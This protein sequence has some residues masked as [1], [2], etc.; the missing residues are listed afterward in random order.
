MELLKANYI[1]TSTAIVVQSNT[2]TAEF[3][4]T[5]DL[6]YQY[7]SSGYANDTTTTT[8]RINF[9]ETLSVDRI[10][11]LGINL[12]GFD[13]YYNGATANTF[14]LTSTGSTTTSQWSS[15]SETALYLHCTP[16]NC[17]SV[18]IDMKSTMVSNAEK[19]L[20]YLVVSSQ[21]LDFSR[22]PSADK[23]KPLLE[24]KEVVHKLSDGNTRIQTIA[25][26]FK[27]TVQLDYI[28]AS[29]RNSLRQVYNEHNSMIF[30]AFGTTTA[31]DTVIFPCVWQGAFE[32]YKH[33]DNSP[34]TGFEGK[35]T[36]LETTP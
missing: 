11:L 36:L 3:I 2:A 34:D 6:S 24:S 14:A 4:M 21:R 22:L 18:S 29:F 27:A 28:T 19:A 30:V 25:D 20:G 32:F 15:N 8:L 12:K 13:I 16:V 17:T 33:S 31:W 23:Y 9:S 7:V 26:K 35:I 5:P 10:A 1:N